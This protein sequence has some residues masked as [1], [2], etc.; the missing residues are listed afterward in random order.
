MSQVQIRFGSVIGYEYFSV[1]YRIHG[2]RIN[3]DVS[4]FCIVTVYPRAFKACR[5]MRL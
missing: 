1:L 5:V 3:I 4:N 2:S